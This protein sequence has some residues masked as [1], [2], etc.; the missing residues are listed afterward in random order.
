MM[1]DEALTDLLHETKT[2]A[3]VGLSSNP[4]RASFG[5]ARFLQRQGYRIIPINPGETE[6]L[7]ERAYPSVHEVPDEV[8][9]VDIFRRSEAVP[10]VVDDALL[11]KPRCIWM[12]EGVVHSEAAKKAAAAGIPVVMDR[13]IL[14]EFARLLPAKR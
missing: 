4:A 6:I 14:K 11:K 7:G 5:V 3:V 8:D 2:I 13:C 1:T 10:E 12:Q 9:I